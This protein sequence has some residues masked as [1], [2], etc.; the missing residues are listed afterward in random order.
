MK[1]IFTRHAELR[2]KKRKIFKE[3]VI[4]A[5]RFPNKTLKKHG[6]YYYQKKINRGTIEVVIEKTENILNVVT[7][8]WL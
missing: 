8:Y 6:L 3:E 2:I 1:I 7:V 4:D 5:I